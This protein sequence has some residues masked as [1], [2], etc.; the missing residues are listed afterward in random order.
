MKKQER[1]SFGGSI[2]LDQGKELK[3]I[4]LAVRELRF[5]Y[6]LMTQK[7]LAEKCGLHFNTIKAI[8]SGEKNYN[9][10]SFMKIISF[11]EYEI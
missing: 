1:N 8:E 7:E 10:L 2:S 6:G 3:L 11:F 9:I 4:G 5:N